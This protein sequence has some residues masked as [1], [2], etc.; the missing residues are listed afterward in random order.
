MRICDMLLDRH[1]V[2]PIGPIVWLR[3][4]DGLKWNSQH[5]G[6]W[7]LSWGSRGLRPYAFETWCWAMPTCRLH[8]QH[9]CL[10]WW[11]CLT[12]ELTP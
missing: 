6:L 11:S 2:N 1:P 3:P 8:W 7:T 4:L 9:F 12:V 10:W 5:D